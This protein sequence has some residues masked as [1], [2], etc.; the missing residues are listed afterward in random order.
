M[1]PTAL[2]SLEARQILDSRG[3]P[4]IEVDVVL[5]DG[6]HGRAAVP[7]G[8][9][10]GTAEA[11][12]LRDGD[13]ARY[14]GLGVLKAAANVNTEI[15]HALKGMDTLDQRRLDDTLREVDGTPQLK[16][17]G[18]NGILGVSIAACRAAATSLKQP[19]YARIA[20][21]AGNPAPQ[22]PLPMV[23]ILSGGLHAGRGMDVQDFLAIPASASSVED[24]IHIAS[25]VRNAAAQVCAQEGIPTLLADEGGLSPGCQDGDHALRLMIRAIEAAGLRPGLDVV[26]AIDVAAAS[27]QQADST[28]RLAREGKTLDA[29]D[30]IAMMERWVHDYPVVSIEDGLGEEDW[31][32]WA[33]LTT[34]LGQRV[35]LVG[36][37]LFTT[38]MQRLRK[39]I[40]RHAGNGILVKVNQNGT[41]TGTLDTLAHARSK[42]YTAI[43]S[44]RSGETED[45]FI[46]DLA[47]GTSAGQIKIGSL[48]TSSTVCKYN[49]LLRIEAATGF[50]YSGIGALNGKGA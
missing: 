34:R 49:Q 31:D 9:S 4:T 43:I 6:S 41:L 7:S 20:E 45:P 2:A 13:P 48:R 18:A 11:H 25:K 46:A 10:T 1:N 24:A 21:L 33:A 36:D 5:A 32:G 30:M 40:D 17:L 39:G 22:M 8:A 47:V 38:N 26:I 16:R 14:A 19:L 3:R 28:Y 42:G 50:P 29:D 44:A 12:E 15:F 37:D 27:L 23:N 35:Q